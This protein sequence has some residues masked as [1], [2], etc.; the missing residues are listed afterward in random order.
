MS[1]ELTLHSRRMVL[2]K[3]LPVGL[4]GSLALATGAILDRA[5]VNARRKRRGGRTRKSVDTS[6]STTSTN[7]QS[8]VSVAIGE[9]GAPGPSVEID[10]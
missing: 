6:T 10:S 7:N 8:N 4:G 9:P 2:K 1:T 5:G 3:A